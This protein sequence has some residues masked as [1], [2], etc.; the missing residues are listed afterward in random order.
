MGLRMTIKEITG[1]S[2]RN[3][4]KVL[5][6]KDKYPERRNNGSSYQIDMENKGKVMSLWLCL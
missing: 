2:T 5:R 3:I 4:L 6:V 1:I